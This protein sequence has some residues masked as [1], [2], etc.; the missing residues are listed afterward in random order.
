M[1][2]NPTFQS[3]DTPKATP[4]TI[5][6]E[7]LSSLPEIAEYEARS[8]RMKNKLLAGSKKNKKKD[9]K[10]VDP[11]KLE[12][13]KFQREVEA[14]YYNPTQEEV[15]QLVLIPHFENVHFRNFR[16][17]NNSKLDDSQAD[18]EK[19]KKIPA[20][21]TPEEYEQIRKKAKQQAK[22][23][24]SK[25]FPK[26]SGGNR[27]LFE[28]ETAGNLLSLEKH[29]EFNMYGESH[30]VL[31]KAIVNLNKEVEQIENQNKILVAHLQLLD[32]AQQMLEVTAKCSVEAIQWERQKIQEYYED[33]KKEKIAR[34]QIRSPDRNHH[35]PKKSRTPER[36]QR[37]SQSQ[38]QTQQPQTPQPQKSILIID[39]SQS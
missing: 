25:C 5:A 9:K 23:I 38:L 27:R 1:S 30:D 32:K 21:V 35:S 16:Q 10:K 14:G 37:Q 15:D 39:P 19:P 3:N 12:H 2:D 22:D 34:K 29:R 33:K 18:E 6:K 24:Y 13:A 26:S 8:S 4:N 11:E 17:F 28:D 31:I 36:Y 20:G 7:S